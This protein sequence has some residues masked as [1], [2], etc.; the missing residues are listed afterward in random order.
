MVQSMY[1]S[2]FYVIGTLE[3]TTHYQTNRAL[4]MSS[5]QYV[6]QRKVDALIWD[7]LKLSIFILAILK[8]SFGDLQKFTG[9]QN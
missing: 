3:N 4:L 7:A 2:Y 9:G 6:Y 8:I 5:V 1:L